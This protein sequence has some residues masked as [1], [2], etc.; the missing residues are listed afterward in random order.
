MMRALKVQ[1]EIAYLVN[2]FSTIIPRYE[3]ET[4]LAYLFNCDRNLLYVKDIIIDEVAENLFESMVQRRLSGEPLQ[5]IT[6]RAGFM[7]LGFLVNKA[8]FIPRPETEILVEKVLYAIRYTL[9]ANH[10]LRI[11]DLCTGCGNIAVSLT[12]AAPRLE[13]VATDISGRA[14]EVAERNAVHHGVGQRITFYKGDLF[15]ALPVDKNF[16]FD[17]IICNPPYVKTGELSGLQKEVR[18]EPGIAL[19]GGAD[20]LD[21][22]RGLVET[23]PGYLKKNGRVFLEVGFGQA[24][25]VIDIFS[26][27][28]MFNI[29]KI[30]K[31]LSG[32]ERV[33]W[34]SLS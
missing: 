2:K 28:K 34:I 31:D 6:G 9:Y 3:I 1:R 33:I 32:I 19:D 23:S 17:I 11:L 25:E 12:K 5:Y 13:I 24:R 8:V 7:G 26:A 16:K 20:G 18:R 27:K 14:L 29:D 15:R 30:E 22:Y 21:F 10:C 4:L